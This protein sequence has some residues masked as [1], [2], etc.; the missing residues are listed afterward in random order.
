MSKLEYPIHTIEGQL[1]ALA[2]QLA[3]VTRLLKSAVSLIDAGLT[4]IRTRLETAAVDRHKEWYSV[5]EFAE[6]LGRRPSTVRD[7]CRLGRIKAAK[8]DQGRGVTKDW[9]IH[10]DELDRYRNH[11]L[12]PLRL[13]A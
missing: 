13:L 1:E 12:R 5:G 6:L 11:G 9:E 7:W 8:R 3:E 10:R 4:E 2:S